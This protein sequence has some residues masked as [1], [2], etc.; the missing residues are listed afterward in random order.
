MNRT[1]RLTIAVFLAVAVTGD[2]VVAATIR[3]PEDYKTIQAAV[4]QASAGDTVLVAAGIYRERIR[5]REDLTLR[6]AGN[7][8]RGKLGLKRAEDTILDGG[9][10]EG[11]GPGVMMA[12]GSTLD[13]L[14]VTNVGLYD[15]VAWNKHHATQGNEQPHEHIGQPGTAGVSV[16]GVNCTIRH[17]IVHH[18]G[19]TGIAI[20]GV[21][22]R[23]CTPLVQRNVC[24]RNMG[25]GIGSMRG[26]TAIIDGNLCFQNFY[27][28]IGHEGAD[29]LVINNECYENI[30]AGIGISEGAKPVVRGNKCYRNRRA[31]IG[32]RTDSSTAPVIEDNDCYRNDMAGIGCEEHSAPLI[33]ANRCFE[34]ALAGIGCRD[35]ARPIIAGNKCYRNRAAGV[36][37]EGKARPLIADNECFENEAAGIGQRG[38]AVTTLVG[39]YLHHN[40]ASGIGFDECEAG[41]SQVVRNRVV[42]NEK[43]AVGI[44]AGWN[45]QLL[46][47]ELSRPEGLPPIVMVFQRAEATFSG[48][49]FRGSGVAAIRTEGKVRVMNNRFECES[50]RTGGPPQFAVWGLPGSD[51]TFNNNFVKSWRHALVADKTTVTAS[52][53]HVE[54]YGSI[55]IKIDQPTDKP[56]AFGNRFFSEHDRTGVVVTGGEAILSDNRIEA[57][58]KSTVGKP[59]RP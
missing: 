57:P 59:S 27:A 17:N 45:V 55:A 31:G 19:Y 34:N 40:K 6:S 15:E 23:S 26:S 7:E 3:V 46:D 52:N 25:G 21:A 43:V 20:Q 56:I 58:E 30:R 47:N 38:D 36:G 35:G 39:N 10:Q 28:G 33:R 48:N 49:R 11:D 54:N 14:T 8:A 42:D 4:D 5:L 50:L 13:G 18:I 9:G 22:E 44:H 24:Y 41:R 53:N 1:P 32:V 2:L 37:S 51:I 29:P 16:L 12:E